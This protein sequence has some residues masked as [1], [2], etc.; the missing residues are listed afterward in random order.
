MVCA[1]VFSKIACQDG[2]SSKRDLST[3]ILGVWYRDKKRKKGKDERCKG[4]DGCSLDGFPQLARSISHTQI[5]HFSRG[6]SG[7]SGNLCS[8]KSYRSRP[9]PRSRT[10][11]PRHSPSPLVCIISASQRCQQL[12]GYVC[13]LAKP[14]CSWFSLLI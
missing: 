11:P 5:T 14:R 3:I 6:S 10:Y 13:K 9:R 4:R 12:Y 1:I 2:D 7:R 8:P